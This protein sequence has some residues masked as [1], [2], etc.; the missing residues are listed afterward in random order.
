MAQ[1]FEGFLVIGLN[2]YRLSLILFTL[3]IVA[4]AISGAFY[5]LA[6]PLNP[7][8]GL[9]LTLKAFS[10]VILAGV[11]NLPAT[12]VAGAVLGLAEVLTSQFLG[13]IWAP[14]VSL[15]I[16]FLVLVVKPTG[17]FGKGVY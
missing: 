4:T 6:V 3:A 10:V 15:A 16:L 8:E 5:V 13:S 7:Y 2:P 12:L 9:P 17:F 11:G 14:A 1:N